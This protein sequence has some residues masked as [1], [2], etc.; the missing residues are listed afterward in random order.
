MTEKMLKLIEKAK[1]WN[2]N[3]N[4]SMMEYDAEN[5]MITVWVGRPDVYKAFFDAD[6]L[7]CKGT[8]C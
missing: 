7:T 1:G 5:N 4:L 8:K 6:T 2:E 3:W